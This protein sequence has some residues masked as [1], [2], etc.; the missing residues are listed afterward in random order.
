[1]PFTEETAKEASIKG[2]EARWGDGLAEPLPEDD[3]W[4]LIDVLFFFLIL[5][6]PPSKLPPKPDVTPN[7]H[8]A[9]LSANLN[10]HILSS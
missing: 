8:C 3:K 1:M 9:L 6:V 7:P 10:L 4:Y 5:P 2:H